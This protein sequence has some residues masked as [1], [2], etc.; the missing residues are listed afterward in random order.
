MGPRFLDLVRS[1][2]QTAG[3]VVQVSVCGGLAVEVLDS[4]IDGLSKLSAVMESGGKIAHTTLQLV[5]GKD[6]VDPEIKKGIVDLLDNLLEAQQTNLAL[7]EKL[8]LLRTELHAMK[9][10]QDD[11]ER[12][13]LTQTPGGALVYAVRDPGRTGE[14]AHTLCANC[15]TGGKKSVLQALGNL[16]HRCPACGSDFK[17]SAGS[18]MIAS[19]GD[20]RRFDGF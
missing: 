20:G 12:Y 15:Y 1:G 19:S 13:V 4:I 3:G 7:Q 11:L 17:T 6:K 10:A 14:P 8:A 2:V 16:F 9:A 18:Q 5:R